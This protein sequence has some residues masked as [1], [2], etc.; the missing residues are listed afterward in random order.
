[1]CR[2][3]IDNGYFV[4]KKEVLN[5]GIYDLTYTKYILGAKSNKTNE[6]QSHENNI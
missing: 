1:M 6:A 2:N 5:V 3:H 4:F